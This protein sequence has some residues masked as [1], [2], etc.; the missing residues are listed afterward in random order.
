MT[1]QQSELANRTVNLNDLCRPTVNPA[2][3]G[4][5]QKEKNRSLA[6]LCCLSYDI[7]APQVSGH[8]SLRRSGYV[9][10]MVEA[11]LDSAIKTI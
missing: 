9:Y 1:W 11:G 3:D 7:V 5:I 10:E 4:I 6:L 8:G 2:L